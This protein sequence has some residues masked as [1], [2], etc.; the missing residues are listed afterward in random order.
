VTDSQ[1][2]EHAASSAGRPRIHFFLE[3]AGTAAAAGRATQDRRLAGHD[4]TRRMGG[5]HAARAYYAGQPSP[6]L[7]VV[8]SLLD[9]RGI[10]A[11]MD[12]LSDVCDGGTKVLVIGH[13]ND[14]LLYRDLLRRHVSDYLVA[15]VTPPQ[16][17]EAIAAAL[18]GEA[19]EVAGR[20]VAFLGAKGGCGSSSVCHNTGW[21]LA[22]EIK[23][24]T[25]IADF[26]LA[27]GTLGL[28]FNQ[29][30]GHGLA[31][32]LASSYKL[33]SE[34]LGTLLAKC[35]DQLGLLTASYMLDADPEVKAEDAVRLVELLS[36]S[37]P[38]T[39]LDLPNEWRGFTRALVEM[40]DDVVITAE[41]DLANLRNAKNLIDTARSMRATAKPPVLVMNRVGLPRR[42]EISARDFANAVDLEPSVTIGFDAQLFGTAANNGLMIGECAPKSKHLELFRALAQMLGGK[43]PAKAQGRG[44]L[45]PLMERL[46][47]RHATG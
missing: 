36:R 8:E 5:V 46:G 37:V 20:V 15:S 44:M 35:S 34:G 32:A 26:D 39:L 14:V 6:D 19:P 12:A 13:V 45:A 10:L 25:I 47:R 17:A 7:L 27:F 30:G 21:L 9:A 16:L 43:R 41:P 1:S 38:F 18:K 11:D 3:D 22:E 29:D 28:D 33:D 31:E 23:A 24:G 42:P 40:A 4:F 2:N